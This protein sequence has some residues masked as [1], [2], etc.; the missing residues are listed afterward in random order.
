ML[1]ADEQAFA[2]EVFRITGMQLTEEKTYLIEHRL[3]EIYRGGRFA[4]LGEVVKA[5]RA[6]TDAELLNAVVDRILTH[7]TSFFR[8]AHVFEVLVQHIIPQWMRRSGLDPLKPQDVRLK[9]WSCG[10]STGQ[11]PYTIVMAINERFPYL[12]TNLQLIATDISA[13]T[14][15][16]ARRAVYTE[17]EVARGLTPE[18][19]D[20]YFHK[21]DA[22]YEF[23]A[24]YKAHV[25]FQ[26]LNMVDGVYPGG[27]DIVFCRNTLIYMED[28]VKRAAYQGLRSSLKADGVLVLGATESAIGY[29]DNYVIR[30]QGNTVY[31]ELNPSRITFF[32]LP[33]GEKK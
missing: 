22:G 10:C 11:E 12:L 20:R 9:I 13:D 26:Q 4:N 25:A 14:L 18:L 3:Q 2:K 23:K 32:K 21:T 6:G 5:L 19:R 16:R 28:A 24:S 29:L 1:N 8:D 7:E 30:R 31:F 17:M 33:P 15:T 27:F